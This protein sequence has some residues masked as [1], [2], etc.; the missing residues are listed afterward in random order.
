LSRTSSGD[1]K[2]ISHETKADCFFAGKIFKK[3][4]EGDKKAKTKR[5]S[6]KIFF[7]STPK[8]S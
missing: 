4:P 5:L 2:N 3:F 1:G 6:G 8:F 7:T